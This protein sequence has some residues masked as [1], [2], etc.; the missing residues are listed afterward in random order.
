MIK[1]AIETITFIQDIEKE[2]EDILDG[3]RIKEKNV[4]NIE[5][6]KIDD[7]LKVLIYHRSKD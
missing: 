3:Y 5:T 1:V 6:V 4:I 2:I 7:C